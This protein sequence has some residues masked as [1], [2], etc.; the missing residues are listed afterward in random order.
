MGPNSTVSDL[1]AA[2]GLLVAEG[3][4][5]EA[6]ARLEMAVRAEPRCAHAHEL[7]GTI[8]HL[9]GRKQEAVR[10]YRRAVFLD[11]LN[12]VY[13]YN[14]AAMLYAL[15]ERQEACR[16]AKEVLRHKPDHASARAMVEKLAPNTLRG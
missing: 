7:L 2:V 11:P 1:E 6:Q 12:P 15:G 9:T 3:K 10:E 8:L 13:L 14:L 4:L 16:F 5:K